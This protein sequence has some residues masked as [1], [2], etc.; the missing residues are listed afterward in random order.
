MGGRSKYRGSQFLPFCEE[1]PKVTSGRSV[2]TR[3]FQA[4]F[5]SQSSKTSINIPPYAEKT[6]A[7]TSSPRRRF[8]SATVRLRED[9]TF[10]LILVG[11]H[12]TSISLTMLALKQI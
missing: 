7:A 10:S 4:K 5:F 3:P 8:P 2:W 6:K 12:C 1:I 11:R 9:E